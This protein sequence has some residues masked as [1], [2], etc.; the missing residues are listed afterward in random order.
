MGYYINLDSKENFIGNSFDA[1]V[2]NLLEDGAKKISEPSMWREGLVCVI[3]N[4][5]FAAAGY[6]FDDREMKAFKHYGNRNY[7]WLEYDKAREL[8]K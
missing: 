2:A 6:A 1:K 7:Q 4:G 8:A 5:L 3:D